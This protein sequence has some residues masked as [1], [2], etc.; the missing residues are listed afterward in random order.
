MLTGFDTKLLRS[1]KERN[2]TAS[3]FMKWPKDMFATAQYIA[4]VCSMNFCC[5]GGGG[6]LSNR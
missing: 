2:C 4:A 1:S 6:V 5:V 3:E